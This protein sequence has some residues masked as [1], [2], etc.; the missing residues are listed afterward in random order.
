METMQAP[1]IEPG[2]KGRLVYDKQK[3]MIVGKQ[4]PMEP[5]HLAQFGYRRLPHRL[6]RISPRAFVICSAAQ[7]IWLILTGRA[8]LHRAWQA[9]HDAGTAHEYRRTVINGGR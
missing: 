9:G 5:H 7:D 6:W 2:A 8:T 1:N 3:R 4:A